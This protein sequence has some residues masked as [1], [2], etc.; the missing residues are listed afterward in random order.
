M[1]AGITG[2]F[3]FQGKKYILR[4]LIGLFTERRL[5]VIWLMCMVNGYV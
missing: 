1:R 3:G 5:C 2:E 4:I